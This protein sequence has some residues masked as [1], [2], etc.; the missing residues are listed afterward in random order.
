MRECYYCGNLVED[1]ADT[2]KFCG[3]DVGTYR[4]IITASNKAYNEGLSAARRHDLS[5]AIVNLSR[6][7]RYN[8][9]N[10]NARNLLGLVYME[11]GEPVLALREWVISANFDQDR[12]DAE[13]YLKSMQKDPGQLDKYDSAVKKYNQA[14]VY[15]RQG[16][17]DLARIQ[18]KRVVGINPKMVRAHQL[19]ALLAIREEK[20]HEAK[21]ELT[22]AEKL[23]AA[24]PLTVAYIQEVNSHLTTEKK[25]KKAS[26][27]SQPDIVGFNDGNDQVIMPRSSFVEALD[28]SRSGL[29][30]ILIGIGLGILVVVFLILPTIRQNNNT[31]AQNAL[32]DANSAAATS[33][34]DAATLQEQVQDLQDELDKYT[35]QADVKGSYEYLIAAQSAVASNDIDG[36]EDAIKQINEDLLD[37]NGKALF[38]TIQS[39]INDQYMSEQ[40]DKGISNMSAGEYKKAAK[41]FKNVIDIEP[42]YQ[43]GDALYR[44]AECCEQNGQLKRARKYYNQVIELFPN[45]RLASRSTYKIEQLKNG[46][47]TSVDT[48][49]S[50]STDTN[51]DDSSDN[52]SGTKKPAS[53]SS[54]NSSSHSGNGSSGNSNSSNGNDSSG[55][56]SDNSDNSSD[57]SD[58]SSDNSSDSQNTDGATTDSGDEGAGTDTA[59]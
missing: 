28:N 47:T 5:S 46:N 14:L 17:Y 6:S 32:V 15:C 9:K 8:K 37:T 52:S 18:L 48:D 33:R 35:G 4:K 3:A 23:D 12:N 24:N 7:L 13:R 1:D 51:S 19:L 58:D 50:G 57:N 43:D 11:F 21:R 22:T 53:N 40:Y 34:S 31:N 20:Y 42:E 59:E 44:L 16:S 25:K 10:T 38:E 54:S 39:N 2:C 41:N 30:N 55:N 45:S 27:G 56:S 49:D 36:A 29:L 26:N